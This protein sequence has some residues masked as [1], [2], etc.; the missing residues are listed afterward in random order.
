MPWELRTYG[1]AVNLRHLKEAGIQ[2]PDSL[3]ALGEAAGRIAKTGK[4]GLSLSM[5]PA[6][7]SATLLTAMSILGGMGGKRWSSPVV[8]AWA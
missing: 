8:P 3:P 1:H 4:V 7:A 2:V 6:D 5:N